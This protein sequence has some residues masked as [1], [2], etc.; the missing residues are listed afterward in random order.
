MIETLVW[1]LMATS[2]GQKNSGNVTVVGHFTSKVQCEHVERNVPGHAYT[3]C[4]QSR[5][6]LP[7]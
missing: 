2:A 4:V 6:L 5:M 7:K 1:I 3:R